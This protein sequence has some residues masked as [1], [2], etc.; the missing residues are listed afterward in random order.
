MSMSTNTGGSSYGGGKGGP[1]TGWSP[2]T[3]DMP[4]GPGGGP[5]IQGGP[6][7]GTT[8]DRSIPGQAPRPGIDLRG[9]MP[10]Q[11]TPEQQVEQ[12]RQG[13]GILKMRQP[14]NPNPNPSNPMP[15]GGKGG[16]QPI[17]GGGKGGFPGGQ[18]PDFRTLFEASNS[19]Y[20]MTNTM[21]NT[22]NQ[23]PTATY[24]KNPY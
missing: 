22:M 13:G 10:Q 18:P 8:P 7:Y 3:A 19:P 12:S 11:L 4:N 5:S 2:S 24:G 17:G 1:V 14:F 15:P 21:Q 23:V 16:F 20:N 6:I 9:L